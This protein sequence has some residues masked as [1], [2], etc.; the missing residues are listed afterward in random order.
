MPFIYYFYVHI[1]D[2]TFT[3]YAC[4]EAEKN[5]WITGFDYL[6]KSTK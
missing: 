2:R 6:I 4:S 1:S 5:L 3:L